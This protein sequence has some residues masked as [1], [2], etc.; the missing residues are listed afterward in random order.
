MD[1]RR[2]GIAGAA[3]ALLAIG[4]AVLWL[5]GSEAPEAPSPE[6][7]PVPAA[8]PAP[9]PAPARSDAPG[10]PPLFPA[11]VEHPKSDISLDAYFARFGAAAVLDPA[12]EALS[13]RR[14]DDPAPGN[15][16]GP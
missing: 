16:L 8:G 5:R 2:I 11:G 4:G 6:G 1:T 10:L 12:A 14:R 13:R 9:E 3:A 15:R 7:V